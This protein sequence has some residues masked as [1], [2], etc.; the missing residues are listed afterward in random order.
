MSPH[1]DDGVLSCASLLGRAARPVI[2]TFFS[3]GDELYAAR[4]AED[5]EACRRLGAE[6]RQLGLRD[7]RFRNFMEIVSAPT[8]VTKR[9]Q[10]ALAA[11]LAELNPELVLAPL[12]VGHHVDH[13]EVR[14]A[15]TALVEP[16]RLLYYEDRPYALV[17]GQVEFTLG[18]RPAP[19]WRSYFAAQYVKTYLGAYPRERVKAAWGAAAPLAGFECVRELPPP[20][21]WP[22]GAYA[23]QLGDLFASPAAMER[24][25]AGRPE[26]YWARTPA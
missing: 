19:D 2:A 26:R 21:L 9:S 22:L 15:A 18:L 5:R 20:D 12:G 24:S 6:C 3:E 16:G 11:L 17:R 10:R 23:T 1:L 8:P 13:R 7:D 25:Y 4:R 14:E